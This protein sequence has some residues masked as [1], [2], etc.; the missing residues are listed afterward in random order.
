MAGYA[1]GS[2]PPWALAA[3]EDVLQLRA[4]KRASKSSGLREVVE[5]VVPVERIELPD[6]RFPPCQ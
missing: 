1:F 4:E 3:I 6:L 2:N 5:T